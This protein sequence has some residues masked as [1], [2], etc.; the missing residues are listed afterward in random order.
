MSHTC[1]I[2]PS[3]MKSC[4]PDEAM[5][6]NPST[7][8]KHGTPERKP[9]VCWNCS[10]TGHFCHQCPKPKKVKTTN[11][12]DSAH[13]A[14]DSD[15][16]DFGV[17]DADSIPDLELVSNLSDSSESIPD[18]CAVLN[19]SDGILFDDNG[20]SYMEDD[21]GEDW[22]S[23]VGEDL[24]SSW[25]DRWDTKE[26]SG[27]DNDSSSLFYVDPDSVSG[28]P[29]N[30]ICNTPN[31]SK[32]NDAAAYVSTGAAHANNTCTELYDSGMT[33]HISPYRDMFETFMEIPLK[34]FNTA[35]QQ[36]FDTIGQGEMVIEVLNG[37][38]AS[39]LTL[40][41]VLYSPRVGYTLV[42]IGHLDECGYSATFEGGQCSIRG[43]DGKTI[44][45][46]PKSGKGLYKV[47][48][49]DGKSLFAAMEKLTVIEL[50]RHMG[51]ILPGITKNLLRMVW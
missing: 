20:N 31:I 51:H 1:C 42:S 13:A 7:K 10:E 34:V 45:H 11:S 8:C 29:H 39:K 5:A 22:F 6:V 9:H 24:D 4:D 14:E 17:T 49:E 33:Q 41:K 3:T 18:L 40:T 47:V 32:P 50:H 2:I 30:G 23:E 48:H 21:D 19:S 38:D 15:D 16:E 27:V 35:N 12:S 43:G 44:G 25:G 26:L 46:I 37:M 36:K 28:V